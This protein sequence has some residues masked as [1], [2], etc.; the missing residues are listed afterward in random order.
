MGRQQSLQELLAAC[1]LLGSFHQIVNDVSDFRPEWG[2]LPDKIIERLSGESLKS[3]GHFSGRL[4]RDFSWK[5]EASDKELPVMQSEEDSLIRQIV[6]VIV[7][8][9]D[10]D[11]VILFGSRAR[12]EARPE[13]DVDLLI[14]ERAPFGPQHSRR[15]ETARLYL[16]LR[17][18]AVSKDLLLYSRDEFER[19]KDSSH[20]VIGR[21]RR[22]GQVLHARA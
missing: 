9:A 13:S 4:L 18:L 22:E 14:I 6:E 16:A 7:R 1:A 20:H 10:P 12:G 8:E 21:A 5:N 17:K 15:Q 3:T 2:Q 11:A 19:F